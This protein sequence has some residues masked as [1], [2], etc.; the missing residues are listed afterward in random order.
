MYG[1]LIHICIYFIYFLSLI[2]S[3]LEHLR[4]SDEICQR[5]RYYQVIQPLSIKQ[6]D[7]V[8]VRLHHA[9]G[10]HQNKNSNQLKLLMVSDVFSDH[11]PVRKVQM[12]KSKTKNKLTN[13]T[14]PNRHDSNLSR[15]DKDSFLT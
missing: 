7:T 12:L 14:N 10:L 5:L 13:L 2:Y 3:I 15:W 4:L 8:F 9:A 1:I 6:N 11:F